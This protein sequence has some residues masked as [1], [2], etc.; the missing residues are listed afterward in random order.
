LKLLFNC[1]DEAVI[2]YFDKNFSQA[3]LNWLPIGCYSSN[4]C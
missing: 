4:L 1:V 3:N 2:S